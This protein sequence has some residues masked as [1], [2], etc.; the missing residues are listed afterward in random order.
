MDV[1]NLDPTLQP[2]I[3]VIANSIPRRHTTLLL[4]FVLLSFLLQ[5]IAQLIATSRFTWA[6]ARESAL[7]CSDFLRRL[8]TRDKL[9]LRTIWVVVGV[10]APV[11]ILLTINT[12]IISTIILEGAGVSVMA[13]Y[14]APAALY[15]LGS[16]DALVGDGRGKW[17]LR[18]W[19]K[20]A[21]V[22]ATLFTC[23]FMVS[24]C[25]VEVCEARTKC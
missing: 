10:A 9:P 24:P 17:T 21:A 19:T 1:S 23:V 18:G 6:L 11:L 3:A 7:P 22:L 8:S 15:L 5:S 20:P 2:S 13:S 14:G 4:T 12:S 25:Q 16:R